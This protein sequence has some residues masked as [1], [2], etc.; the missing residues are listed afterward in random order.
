MYYL[1][2]RRI[3]LSHILDLVLKNLDLKTMAWKGAKFERK[4]S[5]IGPT[6]HGTLDI[7]HKSFLTYANHICMYT[8]IKCTFIVKIKNPRLFKF[9]A[10]LCEVVDVTSRLP[11]GTFDCEQ[12]SADHCV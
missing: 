4:S 9:L 1:S 11:H 10:P 2:I 3:G 12:M 8:G 5:A 6:F 7:L